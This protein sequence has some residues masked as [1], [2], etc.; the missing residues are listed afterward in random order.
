MEI[1]CVLSP[2]LWDVCFTCHLTEWRRKRNRRG[3]TMPCP[4]VMFCRAPSA[5]S[6]V[7]LHTLRAIRDRYMRTVMALHSHSTPRGLA[8]SSSRGQWCSRAWENTVRLNAVTVINKTQLTLKLPC[9]YMNR[10]LLYPATTGTGS[11]FTLLLQ[12]QEVTWPCFYRHR[13]LL[14]PATTGTG[15]YFTL[16]RQEQEVTSPCYWRCVKRVRCPQRIP[17]ACYNHM[18][19]ENY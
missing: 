3:L 18:H 14:Y 17:F 11:Y 4:A 6:W 10:K 13:K 7:K 16:L 8:F 15:S 1:W 9:F 2:W 12:E 19:N 5:A